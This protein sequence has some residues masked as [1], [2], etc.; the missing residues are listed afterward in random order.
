MFGL[1][2]VESAGKRKKRIGRGGSRGGTSGKGHKGQKARTSGTVRMGFE[3]G[4]MP[5]FRRLP[6]R[7]FNNARFEQKVK[8]VNLDDLNSFD[9]GQVV[10]KKVL[11][12]KG[13]IKA[14]R[15]A[16]GNNGFLLKVLGNGQLKKIDSPS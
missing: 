11:I 12:E 15:N 10:D 16:S 7:G 14:Q 3:G 13:I 2:K 1:H 6:K 5:L 4:Q 8:T 9:D